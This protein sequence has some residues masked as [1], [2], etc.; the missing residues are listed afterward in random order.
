MR[1]VETTV[2]KE[3]G[4]ITDGSVDLTI[5]VGFLEFVESGVVLHFGVHVVLDVH[6]SFL[7]LGLLRSWLSEKGWKKWNEKKKTVLEK[8]KKK[9]NNKKT[10]DFISSSEKC[11]SSGTLVTSTRHSSKHGAHAQCYS[12]I[13][14]GN[15]S[16]RGNQVLGNMVEYL[17][18]FRL[19]SL[20]S[21]SL[22]RGKENIKKRTRLENGSIIIVDDGR[23]FLLVTLPECRRPCSPGRLQR[24]H[25]VWRWPSALF[26]TTTGTRHCRRHLIKKERKR[27]KEER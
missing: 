5:K 3:K 8:N 21:L 2:K 15:R 9:K 12:K 7:T 23:D 10:R 14:I 22:A 20:L 27:F 18:I 19:L 25:L 13:T 24:L 16:G 6:R 26:P 1:N 4:K 17:F 11:G